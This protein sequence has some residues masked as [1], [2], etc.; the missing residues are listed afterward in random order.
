[1]PKGTIGVRLETD[2]IEAL[3]RISASKSTDEHELTPSA[4]ARAYILRGIA[5]DEPPVVVVHAE[6]P[7]KALRPGRSERVKR[8]AARDAA[9]DAK[10]KAKAEEALGD[11]MKRELGS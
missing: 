11:I 3:E 1:M 7:V 5:A 6:R 2:K 9:E 10:L 4:L 8:K